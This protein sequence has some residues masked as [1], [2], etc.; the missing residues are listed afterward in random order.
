MDAGIHSSFFSCSSP[1]PSL[2]LYIS[3]LPLLSLIPPLSVL[4][5]FHWVYFLHL[6]PGLAEQY[7]GLGLQLGVLPSIYMSVVL[8]IS[9]S[10]CLSVYLSVSHTDRDIQS[11]YV[12]LSLSVWLSVC[13]NLFLSFSMYFC[14]SVCLISI[15]LSAV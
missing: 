12:C 7:I 10:T 4:L 11:L 6:S 9:L 1:T 2:Y 3:V 14:L 13:L 8:P 5:C 15:S